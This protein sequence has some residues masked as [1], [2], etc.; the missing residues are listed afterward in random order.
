MRGFSRTRA[1]GWLRTRASSSQS[2][3]SF[4]TLG[5][6][7]YVGTAGAPVS[8]LSGGSWS[9]AGTGLYAASISDARTVAGTTFAAAH[10]AGLAVASPPGANFAP[11][12][13]G[14]VSAIAGNSLSLF[15][16]TNCHLYGWAL[17]P[18]LSAPPSIV[19]TGLP[20]G[21]AITSLAAVSGGSI[22][23]GTSNAGMWRLVASTWSSD[24]AGLPTNGAVQTTREVAGKLYAS[25]G[26]SLFV[27]AQSA[28][29]ALSGA[30]SFV[31]A[32]GGDTSVLFAAPAIRR[33]LLFDG[34]VARGRLRREHGVRVVGRRGWRDG[35]RGRRHGRSP[36]PDGRRLAARERRPSRGGG[37]PR[38]AEE[39]RR[40]RPVR[41]HRGQRALRRARIFVREIPP[42]RPR[43]RGGDRSALPLRPHAREPLDVA[44]D[45]HGGLRPRARLRSLRRQQRLR[46]R[47]AFAL[48]GAAR[49]G[50]PPVP[51]RPRPRDPARPL[52][53]RRLD[54]RRGRPSDASL[55]HQPTPCTLFSRTYTAGAAGSFGTLPRRAVRPRGR[56]GRGRDLRAAQHL[57]H[58]PVES[59][60]RS[61]SR[62]AA[63]G[64]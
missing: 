52:G 56:R 22:A 25:V 60:G 45:G 21:V 24:N 15:A 16:A 49:A 8:R 17:G 27:R 41:G 32:L 62:A 33:D 57:R 4:A 5:S 38:R 39:R 12:G 59:R 58:V 40:L 50:R 44:R 48:L 43:P 20:L 31:Q 28:W 47:C 3:K 42:R 7:L 61:T 2:A 51:A 53:R 35:V 19:E 11:D 26:G 64:P 23:G 18:G 46:L 63:P 14:D 55:G 6:D 34:P 54:L 1:P 10:G 30:P 36:A 9:A 29:Q 13:C 37:R